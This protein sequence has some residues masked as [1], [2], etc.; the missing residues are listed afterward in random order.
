MDENRYSV[1]VKDLNL[2][3]S[4][5]ENPYEQDMG[6]ANAI[7]TFWGYRVK[8]VEKLASRTLDYN[9]NLIDETPAVLLCENDAEQYF[10][11]ELKQGIYL[12]GLSFSMHNHDLHIEIETTGPRLEAFSAILDVQR[13]TVEWDDY[14]S[15]AWYEK[16]KPI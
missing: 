8:S 7:I 10:F 5:P 12:N 13:V 14:T 4:A 6:I 15:P 1:C 16:R 11:D 2:H 9:G 3:Q